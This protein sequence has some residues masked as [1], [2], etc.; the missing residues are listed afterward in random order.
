[1]PPKGPVNINAVQVSQ[2]QNDV[3]EDVKEMWF[4]SNHGDIGGS[5]DVVKRDDGTARE[6]ID[7]E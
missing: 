6:N 1:M 3:P 2:E 5:W 7:D 4:R